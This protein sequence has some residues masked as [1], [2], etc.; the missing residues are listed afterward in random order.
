MASGAIRVVKRSSFPVLTSV[1]VAVSTRKNTA[2]RK[3]RSAGRVCAGVVTV[4]AIGGVFRIALG[5]RSRISWAR[6]NKGKVS[7]GREGGAGNFA[8]QVGNGY[9]GEVGERKRFCTTD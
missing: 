2:A 9:R 6:K 3:N 5:K 8:R 7:A 4:D 1:R